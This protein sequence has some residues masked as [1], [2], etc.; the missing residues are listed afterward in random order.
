MKH[1]PC[2]PLRLSLA[3]WC[4]NVAGQKHPLDRLCNVAKSHGR[5]NVKRVSPAEDLAGIRSHGILREAELCS[6]A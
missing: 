5:E 3:Y 6:S 1:A 4:F 2:N